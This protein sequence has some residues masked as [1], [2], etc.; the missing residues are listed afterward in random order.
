[1][2]SYINN[3]Y[4]D[5][6]NEEKLQK[7]LEAFSPKSTPFFVLYRN[8]DLEYFKTIDPNLTAIE[9]IS[10]ADESQFVNYFITKIF[11]FIFY[12]MNTQI[13]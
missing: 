1:M 7:V 11:N 3:S 9:E 12:R 5:H 4:R 6:L 8:E 2:V 13:I 10:K